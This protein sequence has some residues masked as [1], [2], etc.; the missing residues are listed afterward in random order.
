VWRTQQSK[1][2]WTHRLDKDTAETGMAGYRTDNKRPRQIKD[3]RYLL[4]QPMSALRE[5]NQW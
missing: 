3:R 2:E 1:R 5:G 4:L